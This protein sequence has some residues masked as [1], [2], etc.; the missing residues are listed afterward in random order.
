MRKPPAWKAR[1]AREL[2]RPE[3]L[4]VLGVGN[5]AKGDDA[6][7]VRAAE[8]LAR[9]AGPS[10]GARLKVLVT[11][12]APENFTGAV[13]DYGASRVLVIDASAGGFPPG[14][15]FFVDPAEIAN[16]DVSTHRTPLSTLAAYLERTANCRVVILGIEPRAFADDTTLSPEVE[17]AVEIVARWL[18]AFSRRRLRSSSASRRRCS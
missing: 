8:A 12:E 4:A 5:T 9:L 15:I 6:A 7:G 1:L 3:R 13:R 18:A 11:H 14:A 2:G 16:D 10:A 17:S